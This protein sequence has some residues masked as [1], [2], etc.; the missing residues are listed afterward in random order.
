[1]TSPESLATDAVKAVLEEP[2]LATIDKQQS[3]I[4]VAKGAAITVKPVGVTSPALMVTGVPLVHAAQPTCP[5]I[6][7]EDEEKMMDHS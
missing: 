7:E 6:V 4:H 5:P 2:D 3:V 1:M